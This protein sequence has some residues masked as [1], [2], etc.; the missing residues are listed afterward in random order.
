M[1]SSSRS[2]IALPTSAGTGSEVS[3]GAV[4]SDLQNNTKSGIAN[5]S[6]RPQ[7]AL[8]DPRLT[9]SMPPSM[10]ANTGI[11]A[12]AQAIAGM[13][14]PYPT[15]GEASKRAAGAYFSPKLFDNAALK[16]MVRLV[17]RVL[18]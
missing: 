2:L 12:L 17:Q 13:V 1:P 18:P 16:R 14:A 5:P 9:Y 4:I 15:W 10:T 8:V 7:Y 11:D 3:G 6:L